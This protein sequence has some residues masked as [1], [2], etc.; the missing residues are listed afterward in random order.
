VRYFVLL[1]V[2]F[3]TVTDPFGTD[4]LPVVNVT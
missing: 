1:V 2:L 3:C 4:R